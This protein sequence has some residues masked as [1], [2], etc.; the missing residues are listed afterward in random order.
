MVWL[1]LVLM[2]EGVVEVCYGS[3]F[4]WWWLKLCV[5][6]VVIDN[7]GLFFGEDIFVVFG[8]IVLMIIFLYEVGIDVELIYVVLWGILMVVFVFVIYVWWLW[9]LDWEL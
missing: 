7:V 1:L 3:L 9:W 5:F 6:V 2:I 8:V 4:E